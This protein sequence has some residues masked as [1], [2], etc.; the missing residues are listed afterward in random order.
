M[1]FAEQFLNSKWYKKAEIYAC[2]P[3]KLKGLLL[4]SGYYLYKEGLSGVKE[5]MT[6]MYNYLQDIA[7]G[8]YKDYNI[9]KLIIIIAAFIY[10][11]SPLDFLPDMIPGGL[12]DDASIIAWALKQTADELKNYRNN[13]KQGISLGQ[14]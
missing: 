5:N 3:K 1:K 13:N 11:V 10:V 12:I 6:L 9:Q 7:S 2:H 4:Q 14:K 8:K